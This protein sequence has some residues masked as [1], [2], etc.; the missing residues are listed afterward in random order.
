[1][2][3]KRKEEN[4]SRRNSEKASRP[5][6]NFNP[7]SEEEDNIIIN[8]QQDVDLETVIENPDG[9]ESSAK[10]SLNPHGGNP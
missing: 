10:Q 4:G 9:G 1:M 2:E 3:K 8:L 7:K 6:M 5:G